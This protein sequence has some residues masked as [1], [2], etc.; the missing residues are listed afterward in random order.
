MVLLLALVVL[1]SWR[2]FAAMD[3]AEGTPFRALAY[4]KTWCLAFALAILSAEALP[5]ATIVNPHSPRT[6]I[7]V[8]WGIVA[9]VVTSI[10]IR[11]VSREGYVGGLLPASKPLWNRDQWQELFGLIGILITTAIVALAAAPNNWDSMTYHLPRVMHW[12]ENGSVAHYD[13]GIDRQISQP[14]AAEYALL[15]FYLLAD[16][17]RWLNMLQWMALTVCA[18]NVYSISIQLGHISEKQRSTSTFRSRGIF[19]SFFAVS[20]PMAICQATS[21]QND[22]V[23]AAQLSAIVAFAVDAW[24]RERMSSWMWAGL[25]AAIALLSKGTALIIGL[26]MG[27]AIAVLAFRQLR[28]QV[29]KPALFTLMAILLLNGPHW[30]RNIRTFDSPLG[31]SYAL[32]NGRFTPGAFLSNLSKQLTQELRTPSQGLNRGMEKTVHGLHGLLGIDVNDGDLHWPGS[33]GYKLIFQSR[34]EYFH[35]DYASSP[36]HVVILLLTVLFLWKHRQRRISK[37]GFIWLLAVLLFPLILRWQIWHPRLHLPLFILAAPL[38]AAWWV[39]RTRLV[40]KLVYLA[41]LAW[42][43]PFLVANESRSLREVLCT[44]REWQYFAN[45]PDALEGYR[46]AMDL[47]QDSSGSL[48]VGLITSGDSWEYPLW[49]YRQEETQ[50]LHVHTDSSYRPPVRSLLVWESDIASRDTIRAEIG[51]YVRIREYS[52][53]GTPAVFTRLY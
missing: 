47:A 27:I 38:A 15:H 49:L 44:E 48:V 46:E 7:I 35:E 32:S 4:T 11:V 25:A 41:L 30:G 12:I 21:T 26:P 3:S 42:S 37:Y 10:L 45:R 43:T 51:D 23:L 29:W 33:P 17:D 13:T 5:L 14:P 53:K 34:G 50:I 18:V 16:G 2:M 9:L 36:L 22:L 39:S 24:T 28:L 20:V 40:Q 52:W 1:V 31:P 8:F 6:G 19:A